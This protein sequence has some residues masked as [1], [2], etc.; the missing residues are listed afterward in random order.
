MEEITSNLQLLQYSLPIRCTRLNILR[1]KWKFMEYKSVISKLQG[2][3]SDLKKHCEKN[4]AM[5]KDRIEA[6][7]TKY[8]FQEAVEQLRSQITM[9]MQ[10]IQ[11]KPA[12]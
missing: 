3:Y 2:N 4:F 12:L 7:E 11:A 5:L 1:L 6:I 9:V 8:N 10:T